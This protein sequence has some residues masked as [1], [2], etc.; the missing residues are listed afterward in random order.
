MLYAIKIIL[1]VFFLL[2]SILFLIWYIEWRCYLGETTPKISFKTFESIY[3]IDSKNFYLFDTW[4][5]YNG[6]AVDFKSIIDVLRYAGF[7][8]QLSKNKNN[9]IKIKK[10]IELINDFQK[11]IDEYKKSK[12]SELKEYSDT[13]IK[14][15]K[16]ST[17]RY[18]KLKSEPDDN[19]MIGG[20]YEFWKISTNETMT[21]SAYFLS[22]EDEEDWKNQMM[23]KGWTLIKKVILTYGENNR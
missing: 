17:E 6:K 7:R 12:E 3:D 2:L 5:K 10:T 11:T 8:R 1:G 19:H 13:I 23:L 4:F 21:K 9:E 14:Q 16:E 20:I 18:E 15:V 22:I